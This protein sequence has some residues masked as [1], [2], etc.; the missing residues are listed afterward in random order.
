[1]AGEET[2]GEA[3]ARKEPAD[4][5]EEATVEEGTVEDATVEEADEEAACCCSVVDR[6]IAGDEGEE[7]AVVAVSD[8]WWPSLLS[9]ESEAAELPTILSEALRPP[10]LLTELHTE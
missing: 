5:V 6:A 8:S 2:A 10:T 4:E 1:M 9:S 7:M 3:T